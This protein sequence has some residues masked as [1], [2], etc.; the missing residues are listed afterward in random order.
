MIQTFKK[1]NSRFT[2]KKFTVSVF[3]ITTLTMTI[4]G[5]FEIM[6]IHCIEEERNT[7]VIRI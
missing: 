2:K 6:I 1:T 4:L 3:I 5:F 7:N